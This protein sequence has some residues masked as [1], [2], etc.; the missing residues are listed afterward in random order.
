MADTSTSAER[1]TDSDRSLADVAR[2]SKPAL[3][4]SVGD[5]LVGI[6]AYENGEYS[7]PYRDSSASAQ[8]TTADITAILENIQLEG[9][10]IRAY[11]GHHGQALRATV[12][13]YEET[14]TVVVPVTETTGLVA[15]LQND[16]AHDPY[17][18]I[19]T[20]EDAAFE[21]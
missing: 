9:M 19:Q 6:A 2:E 8:Y 18:V 17:D 5:T 1:R 10:G 14:V 16:G 4:D 20:L 7:V 15:V 11:E 12:R 21:R 13:V 3:T